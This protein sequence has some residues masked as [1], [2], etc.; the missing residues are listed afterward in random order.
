MSGKVTSVSKIAFIKLLF[1][2]ERNE[3]QVAQ[4]DQ[5]ANFVEKVLYTLDRHNKLMPF[6]M[7]QRPW[8][9]KFK[10]KQPLGKVSVSSA[11]RASV[12]IDI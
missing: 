2:S 10:D 1:L 3:T 12:P 11:I 4:V 6:Q 9:I 5:I 8:E 7:M